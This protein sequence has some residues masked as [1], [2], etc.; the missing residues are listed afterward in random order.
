[1]FWE[2]EEEEEEE[3]VASLGRESGSW[4]SGTGSTWSF[5]C[6]QPMPASPNAAAGF[7]TP[8]PA[9]AVN[10]AASDRSCALAPALLEWAR[11]FE[12]ETGTNSGGYAFRR[13]Y[14][15]WPL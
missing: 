9:A 6:A 12:C 14:S 5:M 10:E 11:E 15:T 2:E 1:M 4:R 13:T 8:A 3:A 7:S